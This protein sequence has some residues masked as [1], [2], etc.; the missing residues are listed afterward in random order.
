[1][2]KSSVASVLLLG[3]GVL[4]VGATPTSLQA[5]GMDNLSSSSVVEE[6]G[7]RSEITNRQK[8]TSTRQSEELEVTVSEQSEAPTDTET[9]TSLEEVV[10]VEPATS[11]TDTI[12]SEQSVLESS[13]SSNL[14]NQEHVLPA[15][16]EAE[17]ESAITEV[18]IHRLYNRLNGEHL[19]TQDVN[20]KNVL[21]SRHGWGYEGVAWYAPGKGTPVY[22]LYN[23][24]LQNHLYTADT[25]EVAILTSRHGWRKD[26]NGQ[27]VFYSDGD[28]SIYRI[29]NARLRGLH[30]WTTDTNEY[31][32]LPK[33]N[34]QQEGVKFKALH[35]G[36][37]IQTQ[38]AHDEAIAAKIGTSGGYFLSPSAKLQLVTVIKSFQA[39]GYDI[40]FVMMDVHTKKGVEYNADKQ[41]YSA[42]TVKGPF[43]ASLAAKN[44]RALRN[45]V[46]TMQNVLRYSSNE[47]YEYL[48]NTYGFSSLSAWASEAGVRTSI[49]RQLYPYYSSRELF[50]LW[51]R[52]YEYFT[53]DKTGQQ[54]G[55]WFENPNLSPIKSV[56]GSQ[57]RVRSKAGWIGYPGYHAASDAG[58]VYAKS[59]PYIIAIMTDAD[60]KLPMLNT[61]VSALNNMILALNETHMEMA[62]L[63]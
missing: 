8:G 13:D 18:A 1:M 38:Y 47:G 34:W 21:Y 19:Y 5:Q 39:Q 60:A 7:A 35:L 16:A 23:P 33:H 9:S 49:A 50:K 44:P 63:E 26:N 55:L 32:I 30:H 58:I 2:K 10:E 27:P 57:Y 24:V 59:G 20:E 43:V 61:T 29:Y 6:S 40:G 25:N 52:N 22:R 56:L 4:F 62:E 28:I 48:A 46:G 12:D 17:K 15:T 37:P 3:F 41:F 14:E 31:S 54:V 45:S 11:A 42:S 53:N 36:N 51:Q